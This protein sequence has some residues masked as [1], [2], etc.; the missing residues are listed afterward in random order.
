[1]PQ[2]GT[3]TLLFTDLVNSTEHL[4]RSGDEVGDQLFRVHHKLTTDAI[5]AAGGEELQWLGDGVLAAFPSAADAVRCAIK[6]Q[7][8]AR[9]PINGAKFDLRI[10]IHL[11]EVLRRDGGYFGTPVVTARRLCDKAESGQI[12]CS[13]LVADLLSSRQAFGFRDLG[14]HKLKGLTNSIGVCEVIY[15]RDDP[16]AMLNRTPF[17]G[18][19]AQ[20]KRLTAKFD[21]ACHGHGGIAMLRGEPGIGKTRTLE[22]FADHARQRGAVILRGACYDGE[23]QQPFGPFAE[24]IT[25]YAHTIPVADLMTAL[26]KRA[27]TLARIAPALREMLTDIAEPPALEKEEERFRLFDAVAQFL[28]TISSSSPIVLILDDLHWADR[29][30]VAM[31]SHVAHFVGANPILLIGAYR[32]AEVN[33]SHPLS[34]ALAGIGRMRNAETI[35][36]KGI[37][38]A[39]LSSLLEMISDQKVPDELVN[40]LGEATEGNPLFIREV[41]LHLAEEGKI[42]GEGQ[43]WTSTLAIEELGLPETVRQV[44][45]RR[46][47]R[48][49]EE[50]NR[51]LSVASAFNG[52][53][54]FEIAASAAGLDE[55]TGLAAL[56]EALDA[57]LVRPGASNETFDFTHALIRHNLYLELNPA[58]RTRLHR[59]IAEEMERAWGERVGHH[60]AEVAFHFWRGA[61]VGGAER[62]VEYAIAAA[63]NAEVAY[64]HDDVA[65][66]LK[67][68]LELIPNNDSR[69]ADLLKRLGLATTWMPESEDAA[70]FTL[71]AAALIEAADGKDRAAEY[72]EGAARLMIR[73][74]R[75]Q[76]A[77]EVAKVGLRY[78]GDRRDIIWAS[79][80]EIDGYR[81]EAEAT[82]NPGIN[83]DSPRRS[84][85]RAVLKRSTPAE[86][87]ERRMEDF[88]YDSRDEIVSHVEP[89]DIS[90][91]LLG[92]DCKRS[93][94][95][96]KLNAAECE[97]SGRLAM[98][99]D[100]WTHLARAHNAL[101]EFP[102]ARAAYDRAL[103]LSARFNRP[104]F[105]LLNLMSLRTDFFL[106][107]G[108]GWHQIPTASGFEEAFA[109]PPIE[110]KFVVAAAYGGMAMV[111]AFDNLAEPAMQLL[112]TVPEALRRGA[113]WSLGYNTAACDA[114][115]ALWALNRSEHAQ[116]MECSIRTKLLPADFR[117]PMR[118]VRLS[119]ARLCA[120]QDRYDEAHEWFAKARDV[121]D[122]SGWKPLRAV[123]DYDEGLMHLRKGD[124]DRAQPLID[125][126]LVRFKELG[127][128]GWITRAQE[129]AQMN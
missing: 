1:M 5:E 14:D 22:E 56:D 52:A 112:T 49:S 9:R 45:G 128:P 46:L 87:N 66:F 12:L 64:A 77:W 102:E 93:V 55:Q 18:R 88:P 42:L 37:H 43:G 4:Q 116:S 32:D 110:F 15:E 19:A 13:R 20:L 104:S 76:S 90:L 61:A 113:P 98:A 47:T 115:G 6:I 48:L 69:R 129:A 122:E 73:A 70:Q 117:F 63:N 68:A 65:A 36:L 80:D 84:E 29:G 92:G 85:R 118:D 11:G 82:D 40:A 111:M 99:M 54:S 41:L 105:P 24:A 86:R 7:H 121:L 39:E 125:A 31:L 57:Q 83:V 97:R 103:A 123:V 100:G 120:L 62:G 67:I 81:C 124:R 95:I 71:E 25:E 89:D 10:G 72:L 17:V 75:T 78:A 53:F 23:W 28:I 27:G 58:R 126:A 91:L 33:R 59:K 34:S 119:L 30:T 107:A 50:A 94:Q 60:A 101:G 38:P 79:L 26:G 74:G 16:I 44:I 2:S 51:L 21:E 3:I 114:V 127:M 108:E 96:W 109:N 35:A 106:S 8:T